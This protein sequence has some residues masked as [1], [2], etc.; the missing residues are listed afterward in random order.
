[1]DGPRELVFAAWTDP[2]HV[3]RWWGP[4]GFTNTVLEMD[5]RPGGVW[6]L[7]MHGA[8]REDDQ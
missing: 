6:R 7:V 8:D 4:N 1:V 3:P 5:V 2:K